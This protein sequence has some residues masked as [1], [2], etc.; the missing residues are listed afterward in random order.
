MNNFEIR[1]I[2][3]KLIFYFVT[4]EIYLMS[5]VSL[6]KNFSIENRLDYL[7]LN[8]FSKIRLLVE[9]MNPIYTIV[10][11]RVNVLTKKYPECLNCV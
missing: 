1:N 2:C 3:W 9:R 6:M 7:V 5:S 8:K 4:L 10:Y 11:L